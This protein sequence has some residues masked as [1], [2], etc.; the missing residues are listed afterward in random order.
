VAL[1]VWYEGCC[2]QHPSYHTH[3]ATLPFSG[4]SLLQHKI[5]IPHA[6]NHS[7]ALLKMGKKLPETCWADPW[8]SIKL[9]LLHLVGLLYYLPTYMTHDQTRIKV[10]F[11]W[12]S[13]KLRK[14]QLPAPSAAIVTAF[15]HRNQPINQ[16]NK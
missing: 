15:A 16:L 11:L 12:N 5:A 14:C 10:L 7:L 6:V 13:E 1:C 2:L 8:R 9:L 4:P 3:S